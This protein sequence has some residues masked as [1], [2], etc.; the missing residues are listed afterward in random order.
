M[1]S[2]VQVIGKKHRVGFIT[3]LYSTLVMKYD[4]EENVLNTLQYI[5][6]NVQEVS[7][8]LVPIHYGV[9]FTLAVFDLVKKEVWYFNSLFRRPQP[10]YKRIKEALERD[11]KIKLTEISCK[12]CQKLI[13]KQLDG[14]N[15]GVHICRIA[16]EIFFYGFSQRLSPFII[17]EERARIRDIY[18]AINDPNWN[19]Q[20]FPQLQTRCDVTPSTSST[21]DADLSITKDLDMTDVSI[22]DGTDSRTDSPASPISNDDQQ[23]AVISHEYMEYLIGTLPQI[24]IELHSIIPTFAQLSVIRTC[25]QYL[26]RFRKKEYN[27]SRQNMKP[28]TI[29][30]FELFEKLKKNEFIFVNDLVNGFQSYFELPVDQKVVLFENFYPTFIIFERI[31]DTVNFM[32]SKCYGKNILLQNGNYFN[33]DDIEF[34]R[35]DEMTDD[36]MFEELKKSHWITVA[37]EKLLPL[38]VKLQLHPIEAMYGFG[39]ILLDIEEIQSNLSVTAIQARQACAERINADLFQFY[40]MDRER[41]ER[42][43]EISAAVKVAKEI[44]KNYINAFKNVNNYNNGFFVEKCSSPCSSDGSPTMENTVA[45]MEEKT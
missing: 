33:V 29:F 40:G 34:Q 21:A 41:F 45:A 1:N 31:F 17:D 19:G 38:F 2:L 39:L 23:N 22:S 10:P 7:I 42:I 35:S 44:A 24:G 43:A 20:W 27:R 8:L 3:V 4:K 5:H 32:K 9:H 25:Y 11:L 37:G 28:S 15:C 13:N 30:N 12:E 16:E 26:E 36:D 18:D 14:Y 6:P